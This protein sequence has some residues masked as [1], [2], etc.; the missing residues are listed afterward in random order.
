M[1]ESRSSGRRE[2]EQGDINKFKYATRY[3]K[4]LENLIK[5]IQIWQQIFDPSW[6]SVYNV[7][8]LKLHKRSSTFRATSTPGSLIPSSATSGSVSRR[9]PTVEITII[10]KDQIQ[11]EPNGELPYCNAYVARDIK[12]NTRCIVDKAPSRMD[13]VGF[14][15]YARKLQARDLSEYNLM[16]C[17]G[18]IVNTGQ[19]TTTFEF[20]FAHPKNVD[21]PKTLRE[22]LMSPYGTTISLNERLKIAVSLAKSVIFLHQFQLVHKNIR[23]ETILVFTDPQTQLL[24]Q[25]YLIGFESLREVEQTTDRAGY[26]VEERD[27]YQHPQRQGLHPDENYNMQHDIYSLGVCLLEV[28]IGES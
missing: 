21:K 9:N 2:E 6:L 8:G 15:D 27:L 12:G 11:A 3:K 16:N 19:D 7:P 20:V 26:N 17:R 23:P 10:S 4:V 5:D 1:A 25:T 28:G 24:E 18:S 14:L 13:E 22:I